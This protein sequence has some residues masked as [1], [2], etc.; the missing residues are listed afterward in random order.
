MSVQAGN[1][2]RL[3]WPQRS[4]LEVLIDGSRAPD[5]LRPL[6][7]TNSS[8]LSI[9]ANHLYPLVAWADEPEVF[10][11]PRENRAEVERLLE[12]YEPT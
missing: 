5:D 7:P 2:R 10:Y 11:I 1:E 4:M 3:T 6:I 12:S 8:G 9:I